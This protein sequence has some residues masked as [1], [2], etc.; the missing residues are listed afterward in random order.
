MCAACYPCL[1]SLS[2]PLQLVIYSLPEV[3]GTCTTPI[4]NPA[5]VR[6]SPAFP[7]PSKPGSSHEISFRVETVFHA[8]YGYS[9]DRVGCL[10][11][12]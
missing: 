12:S 7:G 4:S 6:I 2:L 8:D 10:I 5:V 3:C 11:E 1:F 9:G